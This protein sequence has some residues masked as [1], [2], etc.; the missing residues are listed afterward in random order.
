MEATSSN[1]SIGRLDKAS[2]DHLAIIEVDKNFD[3]LTEMGKC[4]APLIKTP[5][6]HRKARQQVSPLYGVNG[7]LM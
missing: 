3:Y 1:K 7:A 4:R 6:G 5:L 2:P